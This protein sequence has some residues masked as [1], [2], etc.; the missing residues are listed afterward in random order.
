MSYTSV[1]TFQAAPGRAADFETAFERTGMLVRP[2][3]VAG[4]RG[5]VLHRSLDDRERYVVIGQWD[6]I[7]AY[8][9]WQRRSVEETP[10]LA[11]LVATLVDAQPGQLF[12]A[13]PGPG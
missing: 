10:D 9:E 1:I 5:A 12:E 13:V 8:R 11:D 3:A 4:Y 7:D 2:S 6:T